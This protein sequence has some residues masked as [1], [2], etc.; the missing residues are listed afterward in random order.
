MFFCFF[1]N[2]LLVNLTER[3]EATK[4]SQEISLDCYFWV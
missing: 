2:V 1:G 4:N 3:G